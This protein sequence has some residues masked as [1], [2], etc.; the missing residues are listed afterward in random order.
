MA[1]RQYEY[2]AQSVSVYPRE[3]NADK[4]TRML[5][6][7]AADGWVLDDALAIDPSNLL[8]IYRRP[9]AGGE[10]GGSGDDGGNGDDASDGDVVDGDDEEDGDDASDGSAD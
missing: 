10:G 9:V 8:F 4:F 5:E 6:E 3:I 7:T 2:K 1:D